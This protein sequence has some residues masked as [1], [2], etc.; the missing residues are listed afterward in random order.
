MRRR[1]FLIFFVFCFNFLRICSAQEKSLFSFVLPWDDSSHTFTDISDWK[2]KPAGKYGHIKLG[3]DGH[4]YLGKERIRLFGVNFCFNASVFTKENLEKIAAR[5]AKF[6]IN[7]VRLNGIDARFPFGIIA[8]NKAD[9]RSLDPEALDLL[10]YFVYQLKKNGIYVNLVLLASRP[11]SSA[12]GLPPEIDSIDLYLRYSVG[13]FYEPIINLQKEYARELLKHKNP[14]TQTTYAQDPCVAFMEIQNENGLIHTW[15]GGGID[16]LSDVF[17]REL[18]RQWNDYLKDKYE[19]TENLKKKWK[20]KKEPLGE[21]MLKNGDFSNEQEG[22]AIEQSGAEAVAEIKSDV[23][24]FISG[25]SILIRVVRISDVY[26]YVQLYQP[27]LRVEVGKPYTLSFW[28]KADG[29][30]KLII[31]VSQAHEPWKNLSFEAS[32]ELNDN[33]QKF[34]LTFQLGQDD[35]KARLCFLSLYQEGA[36]FWIAN[37]SLRPGGVAGLK[38]NERLENGSLPIFSRSRFGERTPEAQNEW[39]KFLWEKE[40]DYWQTMYRYLKDELG[41]KGLISGTIVGCSTPNLMA[42]L[43]CLDAHAYW[44]HPVFPSKPFDPEDWFVPNRT[45]VN[46]RGGT[47]PGLALRRVLG[48]PYRVTEYN[49]PAPNTYS[50]EGFLLLSA[51]AALQDWDALYAFSYGHRKEIGMIPNWFDIDQHPTKMVSLIP[52]V[53]MFVRG[54]VKPAGKLV[55]KIDK[56][57]EI[58]LLKR[59]QAWALVGAEFLDVS[60]EAALLYGVAIATS[61]MEMPR[62]ALSP[63]KLKIEGNRFVSDTGELI[64]D[65]SEE[66]RGIVLINTKKSKGVIGYAGGGKIE[67]DGVRIEPQETLQAGWC[68]ITITAVKGE[69]TGESRANLL[70]TATGYTENTDMGWKNA[71]KSSVGKNWGRAPSLVEGIRARITIPYPAE[72][73]EVWSLD[74]K[75]ERKEKMEVEKDEKGMAVIRIGPRWQ[76][77][78]YEVAVK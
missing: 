7:C 34:S 16:E 1:A 77:L 46:E 40:D 42:K 56:D 55:V 8:R 10:D 74:E 12:D 26:P 13:F 28:G 25:K 69:I 30:R 14:Y 63:H 22:W 17:L 29:R 67:L 2:H 15:L 64:W 70:I 68:A 35:P 11:F 54:D 57:K 21:E 41:F 65:V 61:G 33:W 39:I 4:L 6:G 72:R 20:V 75:G 23:P 51:Y 78:W 76:T 53:A 45:M 19:T 62:E 73:V 59:S 71:E 18:Q 37:V 5:M 52:S 3:K 9:T 48:K 58:E 66:G 43:D 24:P 50:S 60:K 47:I 38:E 44:Q 36:N 32:I 49:H 31:S 27:N